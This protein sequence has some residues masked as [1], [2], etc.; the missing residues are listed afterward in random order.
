MNKE[1]WK[2]IEGYEGLYQVSNLGRVKS[3]DHYASNGVANILYRGKIL[4]L[5]DNIYLYANLSKNDI[6]KRISVHRLV[7]KAFLPNP[8]NKL[9]VNH[10]NGNKKDNRV[11]N[12]EWSTQKE[13]VIHGVKTGLRKLKIPKEKYLYIYEEFKKGRKIRSLCEEFNVGRTKI[14][15]ILRECRK[16]VKENKDE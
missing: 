4:K 16:I 11:V 5:K 2:D 13:N 9:Q 7:A 10:I 1:I 14:N 12:L 8:D 6:P 3:L 15:D